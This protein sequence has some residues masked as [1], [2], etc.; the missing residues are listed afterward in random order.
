M[1]KN[2]PEELLQ[3]K[4]S[5]NLIQSLGKT[6]LLGNKVLL[7]ALMEVKE[8]D[9][10]LVTQRE[11]E[12]YSN[13]KSRT[14]VDYSK[15]L[16][17]EFS[18]AQMRK[19]LK[20]KSGSYYKTIDDLLNSTS[21]N[22]FRY[23][24]G[25]D[26]RDSKTGLYGFTEIISGCIYDKKNNKL[27]IKFSNEEAI[28]QEIMDLQS[29]YTLL[30]YNIMMKF[31][32]I[33]AYRIYELLLSRIGYEDGTTHSTRDEYCYSYGLSELKYLLGI[34]DIRQEGVSE[35]LQ[36]PNPDF[37]KIEEISG[38]NAMPRY[39]DFRR[40]CLEKAKKEIDEI[41]DFEFDF[42]PTR[43]GRGGK[44]TSVDLIMRRKNNKNKIEREKIEPETSN[45]D[46]DDFVDLM[47]EFIP[48]EVKTKDCKMLAKLADYN[49]EKIREKWE[50]SKTQDIDNLV[51]WL[52]DAIKNNYSTPVKNKKEVKKGSFNDFEQREYD[53]SEFEKEI[54]SNKE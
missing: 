15:G 20:T 39:V 34:L 42:E 16:V 6:T 40:Y 22:S 48:N 32:T 45:V 25:I 47:R 14:R 50:I 21:A 19:I 52:K 7:A 11:K 31:S 36:R 30:N 41:T 29:N 17:A 2:K 8:K 18:D 46:E 13:L 38:Q 49:L 4:K 43:T 33:Y 27:F 9:G 1:E 35:E 37:E 23:Q 5:N 53:F 10:H 26:I 54:L 28:K 44:V 12:Y 24:W 51:G 3:V